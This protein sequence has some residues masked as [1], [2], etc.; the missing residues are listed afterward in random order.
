M[1]ASQCAFI[2][3]YI[4]GKIVKIKQDLRLDRECDKLTWKLVDVFVCAREFLYATY[5]VLI[6]IKN[7]KG[8]IV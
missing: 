8:N 2:Y 6:K 7:S 5:F 1:Q 4:N 3:I